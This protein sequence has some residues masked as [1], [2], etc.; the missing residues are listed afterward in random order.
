MLLLLALPLLISCLIGCGGGGGGS[1]NPPQIVDTQTVTIDE[2]GGTVT[3][4]SFPDAP[5]VE[6]PAGVL[7]GPTAVTLNVYDHLQAPPA[8]PN[9]A[10]NGHPISVS[11][12][13]A[14]MTRGSSSTLRVHS[15]VVPGED[16]LPIAAYLIGS[17][18]VGDQAIV[19][20]NEVIGEIPIAA[21]GISMQRSRIT[22]SQD[23]F[24]IAIFTLPII[25]PLLQPPMMNVYKYSGGSWSTLPVSEE[26]TK[27]KSVLLV[28]GFTKSHTDLTVLASHLASKGCTVYAVSYDLRHRLNTLGAALADVINARTRTPDGHI[29]V[30]AH[31]MGGLVTRSA[32]E[33]HGASSHIGTLITLGT[34]HLGHRRGLLIGLVLSR[35]LGIE[36]WLP[37]LWDLQ[38]G[39]SF[40]D[41][42][43]DPSNASFRG[44]YILGYG[45]DPLKD[46]WFLTVNIIGL[47]LLDLMMPTTHD[48]LVETYSASG[49]GVLDTPGACVNFTRQGFP[50]NHGYIKE[51]R[52]V[53]DQIDTWLGLNE[54][55][56][57]IN[58][59]D[60]ATMV[61]VP[62]GG[63][64]RGSTANTGGGDESPQRSILLNGYWIYKYEVTVAQYRKFC[65]ATGQTLP[66]FP[67]GYSWLDKSGWN[68]PALQNHP[69]VN[70][71][72]FDAKEYA[73]WT[74]TYLPT[75]AQWEK[76]SRGI[77]GRNY[78]WG[79]L[80]TTSDHYNG[81]DETKCANSYNSSSIGKSTWPVGSFPQGASIYGA[82][83]MAGNA[84]EWCSDWYQS[85]YNNVSPASNPIG[86]ET[87]ALRI[88]RGGSWCD[89]DFGYIYDRCAARN[90]SDPSGVWFGDGFRCVSLLP[91]P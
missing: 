44:R 14:A 10:L 22:R 53:L 61:W 30:I 34:P 7:T 79:G 55:V 43:N 70:V 39:S 81:W 71:T 5:S 77:D 25:A 83:D 76:A 72:W 78:P 41:T 19:S 66:P 90:D 29:T 47:Q 31:S 89:G 16:E 4:T 84:W 8:N 18:W 28:H 65:T 38:E 51:S 24:T 67:T 82:M 91:G 74:G 27:P 23:A 52:A 69:I 11:F 60:N 64:L 50:L 57:S 15:P 12:E 42:L 63:F 6:F 1:S 56:E 36:A 21:S 17:I 73:D 88:R 45:T 26:W 9:A 46:T 58:P 75:E 62:A 68:D 59:I 13:G 80:A 85:D 40:F 32:I 48:G 86:P 37:E 20:G 49:F 54:I 33:E 87:G 35:A 2:T 3:S